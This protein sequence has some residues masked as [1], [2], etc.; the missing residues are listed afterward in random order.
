[1]TDTRFPSAKLTLADPA[2]DSDALDFAHFA[3]TMATLAGTVCVVTAGRGPNRVGRTI[4][5]LISLSATPPSLMVSITKNSDLDHTMR[6]EGGFS[7]AM[8]ATDQFGISDAFA[9]QRAPE[10][11]FEIGTWETWPSGRPK[12]IGAATSIDCRIAGMIELDTHRLFA[13]VLINAETAHTPPLIWRE[14]G[15]RHL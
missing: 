6:A 7:V 5:S 8:L 1:M 13:G 11:R 3:N 10:Q 14:R 4:T 15:Y 12:L 2:K 9:G